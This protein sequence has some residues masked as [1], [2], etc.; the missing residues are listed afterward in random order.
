MWWRG[1]VAKILNLL[2]SSSPKATRGV[3][4]QSWMNYRGD[5]SQESRI[6]I[7]NG[8]YVPAIW[9]QY[10]CYQNHSNDVGRRQLISNYSSCSILKLVW[11]D[12]TRFLKKRFTI[13]SGN[14]TYLIN[15]RDTCC[16]I[17]FV[18]CKRYCNNFLRLFLW[19]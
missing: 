2:V 10:Y 16:F 5:I 8:L 9:D 19:F 11:L 6:I 7:A 1:L 4:F 18:A 13:E 17:N 3:N 15:K 12:K 14:K